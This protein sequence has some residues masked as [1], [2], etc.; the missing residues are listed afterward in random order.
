MTSVLLVPWNSAS[1]NAKAVEK[2]YIFNCDN[3][4]PSTFLIITHDVP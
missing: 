4:K 2:N 3:F 1:G